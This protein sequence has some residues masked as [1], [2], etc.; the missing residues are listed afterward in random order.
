MYNNNNNNNNNKTCLFFFFFSFLL[1]LINL[2]RS[3]AFGPFRRASF[4]HSHCFLL[5]QWLFF[6]E[7]HL[8][9]SIARMS[10]LF[11]DNVHFELYSYV[12]LKQQWHRVVVSELILTHNTLCF[13]VGVRELILTHNTLC[14]GVGV[15]E[16]I[17]T[18]STVKTPFIYVWKYF[19]G[20]GEGIP[21]YSKKN[22]SEPGEVLSHS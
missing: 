13:G 20:Y 14:F 17:L 21:N 18:H 6:Y 4:W 3:L 7:Y 19:F 1:I 8:P 5:P 10:F 12:N 9:F 22:S 15:R 2:L 11:L 16:L